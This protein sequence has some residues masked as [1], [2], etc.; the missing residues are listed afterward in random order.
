VKT[1]ANRT[2]IESAYDL[3]YSATVEIETSRQRQ[4][5]I[6]FFV[7]RDTILTSS[8]VVRG[9]EKESIKI[10][11]NGQTYQVLKYEA[12]DDIAIIQ[13]N[14]DED[15][16]IICAE[17]NP[18]YQSSDELYIYSN[19]A[20]KPLKIEHQHSTKSDKVILF[21]GV[22]IKEGISGSP[23]L[24]A[25]TGQVCGIVRLQSPK[26][27][28]YKDSSKKSS[29]DAT[30]TAT[31]FKL[32]PDLKSRN[33]NFHHSRSLC[34]LPKR[35]YRNF[36]GR[37]PEIKKLLEYI[38]P[39]YRQHIIVVDGIAGIGKTALVIKSAYRCLQTKQD[40]QHDLENSEIPTF[41]SIIF[42]SL[43]NNNKFSNYFSSLEGNST[44]V[45]LLLIIHNIADTF[46]V[47]ELKQI[48]G[49]GKFNLVYKYLS[50][51]RTLLIV[52]GIENISSEESTKILDFLNN[53][54]IS[55]KAI[56]TTRE[57]SLFYS[58]VSL[59]PLSEKESRQ[60]IKEQAK[61]KDKIITP[62]EIQQ[63]WSC[64][65]GIPLAMI[66]AIGEYAADYSFDL[67]LPATPISSEMDLGIFCFDNTMKSLRGSTA[68]NLLMSLAFFRNLASYDV[69]LRVAGLEDEHYVV[70]AAL[71]KLEQLSLIIKTEHL[72][73]KKY[74]ISPTTREYVLTESRSFSSVNP[75]FE[76]DARTRWVSYYR[77]FTK[78]HSRYNSQSSENDSK[79]L[80]S[81][82][83][84]IGEVLFWCANN[85][86]YNIIKEIWDNV[87]PYIQHNKYWMIRFYWWQ[88][89]E[90]ESKKR[91]EIPTHVKALS[92]KAATWIRMGT[93]NCE[94]ARNC[95]I[96]A[97]SL[98]KYAEQDVQDNLKEYI[99]LLN[100]SCDLSMQI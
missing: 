29:G 51:K 82:L 34:N 16:D 83:E 41:D 68:Y 35:E 74:S 3:L 10:D 17:L 28:D 39:T 42:S 71:E 67:I 73:E 58:G 9:A 6:G 70:K 31:I 36:V 2:T 95:L 53:L 52:D 19:A 65:K 47:P 72:I 48:Y 50:K 100:N 87:D 57:Q 43:K 86:D 84:N 63:I 33:Y 92:E 62:N 85:N 26:P 76:M 80:E 93:E 75:R 91:E 22:Q 54:P 37:E 64:F 32:F 21:T 25:R 89:L 27:P 11:R 45:N 7:T 78:K 30:S 69:L 1:P 55:T 38:S 46:K 18:D 5:G 96:E 60:F 90:K 61:F 77:S 13:V 88:Y 44:D 23:L 97:Y 40:T 49:A 4:K 14:I 79:E 59:T 94:A 20:T 66:Y 24:N 81:E 56:I 8:Y 12:S 99:S 98:N 15:I